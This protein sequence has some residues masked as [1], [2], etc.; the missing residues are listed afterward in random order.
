MDLEVFVQPASSRARNADK[1]VA[2]P[3][4]QVSHASVAAPRAA[5]GR[6]TPSAAEASALTIGS[7]SPIQAAGAAIVAITHVAFQVG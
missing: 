3:H 2:S 1:A 6:P 4:R 7:L 5:W